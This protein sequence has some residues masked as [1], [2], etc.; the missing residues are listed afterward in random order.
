MA[1]VT[2]RLSPLPLWES[3]TPHTIADLAIAAASIAVGWISVILARRSPI[4]R[5][6]SV[7]IAVLAAVSVI[8]QIAKISFA[9]DGH[10]SLRFVD[11][12][13]VTPHRDLVYFNVPLILTYTADILLWLLALALSTAST[14]VLKHRGASVN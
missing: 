7:S 3:L 4:G 6:L 13:L 11:H 9:Y 2:L 10:R 12:V 1:D 5:T 14:R 8:L